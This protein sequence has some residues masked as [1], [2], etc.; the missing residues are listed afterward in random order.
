[1][2][3]RVGMLRPNAAEVA[4]GDAL[5][6]SIQR[7]VGTGRRVRVEEASWLD[8]PIGARRGVLGEGVYEAYARESG[9]AMERDD[10]G[11][12]LLEDFSALGGEGFDPGAVHPEIRRFYEGTAGYDL[13]VRME[14]RGP[15]S[16]PPRTLIYLVSR[17]IRQVNLPVSRGAADVAM[18]N[19]I[20]RFTDPAT[21]EGP[22]A[23]WL[24]RSRV[25]GEAIYA[26]FYGTCRLPGGGP[27]CVKGS[28][29][30][31]GGSAIVILRPENRP[32]GS[33]ALVS[34]GRRFG[35]AGYYR[36]HRT[37]RG[38]LRVKSVPMHQTLHVSVDGE[39][40]LR[41][42]HDFTLSGLR[43]LTLLFGISRRD[44][45]VSRTG[46]A[47]PGDVHRPVGKE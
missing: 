13:D 31:P 42:R 20:V 23:G 41:V 46:C 15:L 2:T 27:T 11:A 45:S 26:G 34:D 47:S 40:S 35:E 4:L 19:E 32:D 18:S 38:T 37:G 10:A 39:S 36:V 3:R 16:A 7:W 24:R 17:N 33:F 9:L 28:Y 6:W 8:G 44:Q 21:G 14:W 22:F 30:M 12:G 25:T 1:M 5:E 29:P 43:F